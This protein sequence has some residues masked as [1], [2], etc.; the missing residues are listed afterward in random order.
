[1]RSRGRLLCFLNMETKFFKNRERAV[2]NPP[3]I[4]GRV[5]PHDLD[6]E[7]AVLS[8][9]M[10]DPSALDRVLE[11]LKADHFY[12]E[13][14]RRIFEATLELKQA[15]K[16]VD[17]VQVGSW[18]KDRERLAQVG[19]APYLTEVL[20][21]APVVANVAS[22]GRIIHEKWRVRQLILTCQRVA[23]EGY[24]DYGEAQSFIDGAEQSIYNLART[25]EGGSVERLRDVV[26]KAFK[27]LNEAVKRGDRITGVS[28][29]FERYDRK[30]A[31]LH[32]GDLTI[33]AARPGMGKTSFV[34]N[35]AVNVGS[36][37][38][39]EAAQTGEKV[40]DEGTGVAVFSLEMPR[41]QLANRMVCS[42]ARVDVSKLRTGFLD[43]SDWERLTRAASFLTSLPI[44]IDDSPSLSLLELRAKVRR[45]QAE[46]DRTD[47]TGKKVRRLGLVIIDYLQLMRGR[48]GAASR[49]QEISEISRGLK[50]LAKE[51]SVPVIALSQLNRAVETRGD[52]SK[53]PMISDL[54]ESGAIEQDADN[55]CF[56]YRD[57]YYNREDSQERNIAELIIAKQRNGPTGTC[58][59]RFEHAY[60]RF[61]NLAEGEYM[62]EDD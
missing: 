48:D 2:Q 59:V 30:T 13:A 49:E 31:G 60:T 38:N 52:K 54:R 12:S 35:I 61:D 23:A 29:G 28:T 1:M 43:R 37:K 19:G 7:A 4:D 5:P 20:N 44:W 11:F 6:A 10:L 62:D 39:R 16:P 22:Y 25:Q 42:E 46:Y 21:A 15:G 47:D 27:K 45:L 24:I 53:R 9:V 33:I 40:E 3:Q 36:P 8:A 51:L 57:D 18:L 41:E 32:D 55:I 14:H 34:L 26:I 58:K 50:G 56:I 17:V